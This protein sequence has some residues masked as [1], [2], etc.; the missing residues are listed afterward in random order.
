[1]LL[2]DLSLLGMLGGG[3]SATAP[4]TGIH[5]TATPGVVTVEA[6][7]VA[8]VTGIRTT[9]VPGTVGVIIGPQDFSTAFGGYPAGMPREYH[10]V[11]GSVPK[12]EAWRRRIQRLLIAA[13]EEPEQETY[14][15]KK[16]KKRAPVEAPPP[17]TELPPA[18]RIII[19]EAP[20]IVAERQAERHL[21]PL[22]SPIRRRS[23]RPRVEGQRTVARLGHVG[24]Q[25]G[26]AVPVDGL[27]TDAALGV[28][29]CSA[30]AVAPAMGIATV[31]RLGAVTIRA[32]QNPTDEEMALRHLEHFL[33]AA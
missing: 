9:A 2:P 23:A 27:R 6:G 24:V 26:A 3:V 12:T 20:V 1:M 30:G 5:T 29:Q 10:H 15:A 32:I 8:A 14:P 21:I 4:V 18:R 22:L 16:Q 28:V 33:M 19:A 13:L 7:A 31:G 17:A 25:A 11:H